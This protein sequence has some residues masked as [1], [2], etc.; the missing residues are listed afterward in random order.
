MSDKGPEGVAIIGMAARFPGAPNL[1]AFWDN[2]AKGVESITTTWSDARAQTREEGAPLG[3]HYVPSYGLLEGVD[4]F[5][6]AFF[7]FTPREA[8]LLDPQQRLFLELAWTALEDGG[9]CPERVSGPVGVY[10]GVAFSTYLQTNILRSSEYGRQRGNDLWKIV[11]FNTNDYLATRTA[12]RLDLRGPAVSVQSACSTSLVAVHTACQALLN[13]EC[14]QALAGGV[15]LMLPQGGYLYEPGHILSPDG[16]CRP[17]DAAAGGTVPGS[18]A[19]VVLL[20]RLDEAIEHRDSI[21]AVIRGSAIN[22]DGARKAGYTA[23]SPLGQAEAIRAAHAVSEIDPATLSMIECH[24]TGTNLG[25]PIEVRGL[26]LAFGKVKMAPGSCAIGS[27][28]SNI[29]HTDTASGV[30]SLIK[31]ALA[32]RFGAIPASLNFDKPHPELNLEGSPFFVNT[33]LRPWPRNAVPRRAGVSSFGI[34]GT[35]AHAVLEEAP[36]AAKSPAASREP[37]V[38]PLSA[39]SSAALAAMRTRL[40]EQLEAEPE[41]RLADVA[42]TLQVG[43]RQFQHRLAVVCSNGAE[44]VSRLRAPTLST[45]EPRR[46]RPIAFLFSGQGT[47]RPGMGRALYGA[48][49][50]FRAEADRCLSLLAPGLS[51]QLRRLVFTGEAQD[52]AAA[53]ELGQT[54]VTQPGLFILEHALTRLW[55]SWGVEPVAVA[56]HSLGELVAATVAGVFSVEDALP[57]VV[58]RA[59]RMQAIA[60]G[61]MIAVRLSEAQLATRIRDP[62]ALAAVNGE[63]DCVVSGPHGEIARLA[64]ALDRDKVEYRRLQTSHAFH[65]SMMDPVVAPFVERIAAQKLKPPRVPILSNVTGHWLRED[66]AT[67]PSYWGRQ[68]RGAVRFGACLEELLLQP[69][70]AL[71]EVGPGRALTALARR[72]RGFS[73]RHTVVASL[74]SVGAATDAEQLPVAVG[75]L[76]AAGIELDW[77][78]L[79]GKSS[80]RRVWLPSYPFERQRHWIEA[81]SQPS[82]ERNGLAGNV[83]A[84]GL[85]GAP[86]ELPGDELHQMLLVGPKH[87]PYL[88]DHVVHGRVLVPASFYLSALLA[89]AVERVGAAEVTLADVQ[90]LRPLVV[91]EELRMHIA[92]KPD[93]PGRYRYQV[94]TSADGGVEERAWTRHSEGLL[95][96]SAQ[97]GGLRQSL[98]EVRAACGMPVATDRLYENLAQHAVEFGPRWRWTKEAFLGEGVSLVRLGSPTPDEGPSGPIHPGLIDNGLGSGTIAL[99]SRGGWGGDDPVLPYAITALRYYRPIVGSGWCYGIP[100]SLDA[101]GE[102]QSFDLVFWTDAGELAA[103]IDGFTLKRAPRAAFARMLEGGT[104]APFYQVGWQPLPTL[105][106]APVVGAWSV[107]T[108]TAEDGAAICATLVA[109]GARASWAALGDRAGVE[110]ALVE[111]TELSGVICWWRDRPTNP[112]EAATE[113]CLVA[114]DVVHA[115]QRRAQPPRLCWVTDR[116]ALSTA[117]LL[118][119]GRVV[120]TEHPEWKLRMIEIAPSSSAAAAV[121]REL[122][123]LDEEAHVALEEQVRLGARLQLAGETASAS[124]ARRGTVLITG[125]L[126]ALGLEVAQGLVASK[127][128]S[129]LVLMGRTEPSA[130][131]REVIQR[132]RGRDTQVQILQGDVADEAALAAVK[133]MTAD[134]PLRG[135]VHAAGVLDDGV[136]SEQTAARFA[137]VLRAKVHGAWNLHRLTVDED[138]DFFAMFSSISA[139]FGSAGQSN[140]AAANAFLDGLARFRQQQGLPAISIGW[141]PWAQAGMAA[142]MKPRERS[143]LSQLGLGFL[144]PEQ[145][146]ALLELALGR[147][148]AEL[149]ALLLDV[150]RL[151]RSLGSLPVPSLLRTLV[152]TQAEAPTEELLARLKAVPRAGRRKA[153]EDLLRSEVQRVIG[154]ANVPSQQPLQELGLDSLTALELRNAL[155]ARVGRPLPATLLFDRPTI[156]A[157]SAYL[158][159]EVLLLD[160]AVLPA[161][162]ARAAG[163]AW[164]EPIAIIGLGCRYP[165]GVRDLDGF[166]SVVGGGVDAVSEV[167]PERW[168]LDRYFDADPDALGK[169]YT[170]WGGF[171]EGLDRFDPGFFGIS[172]REAKDADPQMRMLL[173]VAWEALERAGLPEQRLM[174]SATGVYMG[175]CGSEYQSFTM[176]DDRAINAYSLLGTASSAMVGRLSYFLGLKGPNFP[177]DTACSSSLVA[178]H[179]ACQALRSGD[180]NLALA[181][182]VSATLSP[183]TTIY[184]SR[185]KAMSP[186]GRC[187][188]FSAEA[189][190]Y[191]RGEGCGIVVLKRLSDAV[192]DGDR[193]WAVVRGTAVNQD[194]RSQGMTAPHGPSQEAVIR[195]ALARSGLA[196]A[197]IDYV[198][199][200]GTGTPLGDPIEVQALGHVFAKRPADRP[201]LMGSAKTNFGH[202]EGAAGVAGLIKT[203]LSLQHQQLPPSLHAGVPSPHIP[204]TDLPVKVCR[205]AIPW[206]SNGRTRRAGVSSF[207]FSGTNAHVILEEAPPVAAQK[208]VVERRPWLLTLSAKKGDALRRQAERLAAHLTAHP[209][210]PL[211]DVAHALA[212]TRTLFPHRLAFQ[213][214]DAQAAA[215]ILRQF[216][217]SGESTGAVSGEAPPGGPRVAFLFTGQGSQYA[218]MGAQL[219]AGEPVFRAAIDRCAEL[220]KEVPLLDI[221]YPAQGV[222]AIDETANTQPAL[223]AIGYALSQLWQSWGIQPALVLGHS[224]GEYAAACAAGVF[225]L[226][227]GLRLIAARGR[228]MQALTTKGAMVSL[229]TSEQVAAAAVAAHQ[230]TVALA[231]VNSPEQVVISGLEEHVLAIAER[232]AADG[233]RTQRLSV[234]HAF[235]SP[236]M[237][238]MVDEF[239][240][241]AR[242]VRFSPAKLPIVS[243]LDGA[244]GDTSMATP[245][246]WIRQVRA[247]VRFSAAV[248]TL[249]SERITA[250]VEIGPQPILSGLAASCAP[251]AAVAWLAS[252]RREASDFD[253]MLKALSHLHVAGAEVDWRAVDGGRSRSRV[254]LPTY[255]FARER[256]WFEKQVS[257]D[258][259]APEGEIWKLIESGKAAEVLKTREGMSA[260]AKK[261]LDEVLAALSAYRRETTQ[262]DAIDACLYQTRWRKVSTEGGALSELRGRWVIV[263]K[264]ERWASAIAGGLEAGGGQ[265][266]RVQ[267]VESLAACLKV[268]QVRVVVC[269]NS[270]GD[271][272]L[273]QALHALQA[274]ARGAASTRVWL[275]TCEAVSVSNASADPMQAAIWGLGRVAS[276]GDAERWGG[277]IDVPAGAPEPGIVQAL[278]RILGGDGVEDQVALRASGERYVPRLGPSAIRHAAAKAWT[279]AGTALITGGLGGVGRTLAV[280]VA[281]KG[282]KRVVVTS[283][284]GARSEGAESLVSLLRARGVDVLVAEGDASDRG[285]MARIISEIDAAGP[286]LRAVFHA[287]GVAGAQT[288]LR[289]TTDEDLANV[290]SGKAGG[291]E[292]LD[293]LVGDRPLDAFVLCSS[294]AS[295]WG[296]GRQAS[297]AA[298]NAY[299][300]ALARRRRAGGRVAT[301]L[302]FGPWAGLG[303]AAVE[304]TESLRRFGLEPLSANQMLEG[305]ERVLGSGAEQAVLA[306]VNWELFR[307]RYEAERTRPLMSELPGAPSREAPPVQEAGLR[308]ELRALDG[309]ARRDR[310]RSWVLSAAAKVLGMADVG[311]L[312]PRTGFFD[313]GLDS[314]MALEL[315]QRVQSALGVKLSA[316]VA[317]N[318]PNVEALTAHLLEALGMGVAKAPVVEPE[319]PLV[320]SQAIDALDDDALE[321]LIEDEWKATQDE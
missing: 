218:K 310:L 121:V 201:L 283:R 5:D 260:D 140:Y 212:T 202:T 33:A 264:D 30:A 113:S 124:K 235:H 62:L 238:P 225:S 34:G 42:Y 4:L 105:A 159:E 296:S 148:E 69:D 239:G 265:V 141:S 269:T 317:F 67:D 50:T 208:S 308:E 109:Q 132:L 120:Q 175:V 129:H 48:Y 102:L 76:W 206:P 170:R 275:V 277:L 280:W 302:N 36:V 16:R 43:R 252:M 270:T 66:E 311:T 313:L 32:L 23:P 81:G 9:Y 72:G 244:R 6:A 163:P 39:R 236:L 158:L 320:S 197:D 165:G 143:R 294:I 64:E 82:A 231:A 61:A 213:A 133:R 3:S 306:S 52:E 309:D 299:L 164:D 228:L 45:E 233:V 315:R 161:V 253:T 106:V 89:M 125:G 47:Q 126:G 128:C 98:S 203:V 186:T 204:W 172:P 181:G 20:K 117:A 190:G 187:R 110:R 286:P 80:P 262:A 217:A 291:A 303:M 185:L 37:Q 214:A 19:G 92:L 167:P 97:P 57:L 114:L 220:L 71:L 55:A 24:G 85:S 112:A 73:A 256:H 245:E 28:K 162:E 272:P 160:E 108:E 304:G 191:V 243:T 209:D 151:R 259:P 194:G 177:I 188:T 74:D 65:S 104:R 255:A 49:P 290:L 241:V 305:L 38:L 292:V 78:A 127:R 83:G 295:V 21:Y 200:H 258:V 321:A 281:A 287:A 15:S 289:D 234:S 26:Q 298:A 149:G 263:S 100:R 101:M 13:Y 157:L 178:L 193:I 44:A 273:V 297:Y 35:N 189:D 77:D 284:S 144:E 285:A 90:M 173:E 122:S 293:G 79:H 22:N 111:A 196:P 116:G 75:Q 254:E 166:W 14:D 136:L 27:V 12:H 301:V 87:Q 119:F 222:S 227:D 279:T 192:A 59:Q 184:F 300:D 11:Q 240:R 118:G 267:D 314:L 249:V 103:E 251:E 250:C 46:G 8:A 226:E 266:T 169:M 247:P 248:A 145:G 68:L 63:R 115:L 156:E 154:V 205:A 221:L 130:A 88:A 2:L 137:N 70:R 25:D 278:L 131:A 183:K 312:S 268:D 211:V 91:E 232:L 17:F 99:A 155:A 146:V 179:T 195:Q 150:A 210:L 198:E 18:G 237:E 168:D 58:D 171:V 282:A 176:I 96:T 138:L 271:A 54:A 261:G 207:G 199:C 229:A 123:A 53:N 288:S 139:L 182:G 84:Y 60:S 152:G 216:V 94:S 51:E 224:V 134:A 135:V 318:H 142:A 40:A 31:V 153:L 180:C 230:G 215:T 319:L 276:L 10:A 174:G 147:P 223:F 95:L 56:G 242:T 86:L 7:G 257:V 219:Y 316:T 307:S 1:K 41:T 274:V 246:Y 93:G 107:L 29:G